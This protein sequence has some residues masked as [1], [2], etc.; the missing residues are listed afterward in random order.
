MRKIS[1]IA[2]TFYGNRGAEAMLSTTIGKMRERCGKDIGFN[3]FSYYPKRDSLLVKDPQIFLYSATP[4]YLVAVLFP[5]SVLF[6]LFEILRL[7]MLQNFLPDSV[8]ALANSEALVCLAGVSFVEGRTKF[9]LFNIA[10]ILP[11]MILGVPVI[12]FS[13]AMGSFKSL[14]NRIAGKCFLGRCRQIFTRGEKTHSYLQELFEDSTIFQRANDVALLFTPEFCISQEVVGIEE[15]L[16]KLNSLHDNGKLIVGICPS[17]VVSIRAEKAGWDYQARM[18]ELVSEMVGRGYVV[19]LYPNATRG[20]DMD[21]TH[22]NDLPLLDGILQGLSPA[23]LE[24]VISFSGSLNVGQIYSIIQSCDVH[25]VSRFHAMIASLSLAIPVMV[26]GWSHKY[27][28]VMEQFGQEDM[29]LDYKKGSIEPIIHC[30]ERLISERS[31]RAKKI[32]ETLP[33]NQQLSNRQIDYLVQ[34][35]KS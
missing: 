18:Q 8:R 25:A 14:T 12:K 19:A 29:V 35:L 23:T 3:V 11:A 33:A 20:E 4:L 31:D 2:G 5:C 26:I 21:K 24:N 17:V 1:I 10:T 30:I 22:N 13:Q 7:K 28:E 27:L 32:A 9:I 6:R 16:S 34:F 15:K